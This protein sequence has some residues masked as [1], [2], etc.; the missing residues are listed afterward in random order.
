MAAR[1]GAARQDLS[2]VN[3]ANR[4]VL[5]A[6]DSI[7]V[8]QAAHVGRGN[9]LGFCVDMVGD[10]VAS[11]HCRN[12]WFIDRKRSAETTAFI[13]TLRRAPIDVTYQIHHGA[14]FVDTRD[15]RLAGGSQA[16]FA[17]PVTALM[18]RNAMRETDVQVVN[19]QYVMQV[20]A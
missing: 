3:D 17:Q 13:D 18:Q 16:K 11:H 20:F 4:F 15:H 10:S 9:E 5:S 12:V 1:I 2:D 19:L 8:H 7:K 6:D 14:D